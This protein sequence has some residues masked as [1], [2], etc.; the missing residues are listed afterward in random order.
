MTVD[1]HKLDQVVIPIAD[2]VPDTVSLFEQVNTSLVPGLHLLIWQMPFFLSLST[3][4]SRNN[5]VSAGKALIA[6]SQGYLLSS[7]MS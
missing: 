7:P 2:A 5:F 4:S 1:D 6:L 3:K